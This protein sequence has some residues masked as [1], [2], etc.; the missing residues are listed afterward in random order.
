MA[1]R[2]LAQRK[3]DQAREKQEAAARLKMPTPLSTT[4]LGIQ[5]TP[6]DSKRLEIATKEARPVDPN[7]KTFFSLPGELRN[8]V[9]RL[10]FEKECQRVP[11]NTVYLNKPEAHLALLQTCSAIYFEARSFMVEM[12]TAYVPIMA[13]MDWRYGEPAVD[14]GHS[15][16]TKDTMV[17]A[18]TDFMNVHLQLHVELMRKVDYDADALIESLIQ[19]IKV[20]TP[21]LWPLYTK[22]GLGKRRAMVHLDHLLSLWPKFSYPH[23]HVP[24]D[25]LQ[26]IIA[27][28]SKDRMTDWEIRHYVS[29]GQSNTSNSYGGCEH[30]E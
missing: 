29:T 11:L 20:Y 2:F 15:R 13:G 27:L 16:E 18:L 6:K 28:I 30:P 25:T 19:A 3:T 12:Q 1:R 10:A 8:Q 17:C 21:Q 22:H 23:S 26:R 24:N 7:K 4:T 9:Y 14:Y 5:A